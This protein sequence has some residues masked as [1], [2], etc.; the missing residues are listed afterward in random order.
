LVPHR[1]AQQLLDRLET[2]VAPIRALA[3]EAIRVHASLHNQEVVLRFRGLPFVR[4][5]EGKIVFGADAGWEELTPRN[6][7]SLKKLVRNLQTFRG[8]LAS[9]ARQP[10]YRSQAER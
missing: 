1:E 3:P 6:E 7:A 10:L 9:D 2:A 8:P 5:S 4:W